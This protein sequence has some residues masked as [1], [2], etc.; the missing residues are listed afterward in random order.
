M[1]IDTDVFGAAVPSVAVPTVYNKIVLE[2]HHL[3]VTADS[4]STVSSAGTASSGSIKHSSDRLASTSLRTPSRKGNLKGTTGSSTNSIISSGG[5]ATMGAPVPP[6]TLLSSFPENSFEYT[7]AP[8]GVS[9]SC[10]VDTKQNFHEIHP[11]A[12]LDGPNTRS[13][14]HRWHSIKQPIKGKRLLQH[15]PCAQ[16]QYARYDGCVL[17]RLI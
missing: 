6:V 16:P 3:A 7:G 1:A 2:D 17:F 12:G 8:A 4:G 14:F 11:H 10:Q 5:L 9:S 15:V 13:I